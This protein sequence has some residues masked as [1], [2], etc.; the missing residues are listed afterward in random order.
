M[1]SSH[2]QT[3]PKNTPS[4]VFTV[5]GWAI[6]VVLSYLMLLMI[7]CGP[8]FFG[9]TIKPGDTAEYDLVAPRKSHIVDLEQ[10]AR[11]KE[12]A[13]SEVVAVMRRDPEKSKLILAEIEK[14]LDQL[15]GL[16][17]ETSSLLTPLAALPSDLLCRLLDLPANRWQLLKAS[18]PDPADRELK[19]ALE[20][21]LIAA[22]SRSRNGQGG[23]Q[24]KKVN[25]TDDLGSMLAAIDA[26][27]TKI[28]SAPED[29][30][31]RLFLASQLNFLDYRTTVK[32]CSEKFVNRIGLYPYDSPDEWKIELYEFLPDNWDD[33][34]RKATA[35][36]VGAVLSPNV[37][38]DRQETDKRKAE[39]IARV[40][41]SLTEIEVGQQIVKHGQ[42]ITKENIESLKAVGITELRNPGLAAL[43]AVLLCASFGFIGIFLHQYAPKLFFSPS[44]LAMMSTVT[45]VVCLVAALPIGADVPQLIPLPAAT[46]IL[47][48]TYGKRVSALLALL[49]SI[50][51]SVSGLLTG[52]YLAALVSAASVALMIKVKRRKDLMM[53]GFLIGFMQAAGYL[54][55]V[56]AGLNESTPVNLGLELPLQVAG[57]LFSSVL[58]IG[59]LPFLESI[60]GIL[61]PYRIVELSE[62]DQPLMRQLEENAPGTYQHSLAVANLAEGGARAIGADVNLV[63]T[64]A[65]YHDIGKMVTPRYFIE[66][67]LGDKNPHDYIPPEESRAK[68]L[69][70]V[71]N[72]LALAQK[73]GLP[74]AIQAFIPEHQGTTIMAYFY[75]KACLR[76]GVD[77]VDQMEYRYPGPKPQTKE[78]AIV[79][80]ADV[81]EAVTHSMKDPSHQ[82]VEETIAKVFKARWDDQQFSES[83][84]TFEELEKVKQG[85]L[86]VW[87]TLHH[88]RLKYPSTTTGRMAVPPE[89][90]LGSQTGSH[91]AVSV[92]PDPVCD[93]A[94]KTAGGNGKNETGSATEVVT[95]ASSTLVK[96]AEGTPTCVANVESDRS[97][98]VGKSSPAAD[99]QTTEVLLEDSCCGGPVM[100]GTIDEAPPKKT[101]ESV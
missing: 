65:M 37:S 28:Q 94:G 14:V 86:R 92:S 17:A 18:T 29:K 32:R 38:V 12:R 45:I 87:R 82:E 72:G 31:E 83:G 56:V 60:F 11:A 6:V 97:S 30:Q 44:S 24:Q 7:L 25:I 8:H 52:P 67:Q 4:T 96:E 57:G 13:S 35:L 34:R 78:S 3:I 33:H 39:A 9:H 75:H 42:P 43:L 16:Q 40:E 48:L 91:Q 101:D 66:N 46:L 58:A 23:K 69:A 54:I 77:N 90:P 22:A 100:T 81:S 47:S 68:V 89:K 2:N 85:F 98:D 27:R 1:T 73:Y 99:R 5:V 62:P 63:H 21:C 64:G 53:T 76:D 71:T 74:G 20:T 41:P 36:V 84:L 80:L 79:M 61:T 55:A 88:D 26:L 95:A 19:T 51:L 49:I 93:Q 59:T 50:F 15:Q 70:H 10:T